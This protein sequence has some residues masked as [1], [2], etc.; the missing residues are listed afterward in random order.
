MPKTPRRPSRRVSDGTAGVPPAQTESGRNGRAPLDAISLALDKA[1]GEAHE[2]RRGPA[3]AREVTFKDFFTDHPPA[4]PYVWGRHTHAIC[5]EIQ[6]AVETIERGGTYY[7]IISV[8]PRHGKSDQ[9][10]RR[11]GP[12][13]LL[14]NPDCEV[15]LATYAAEISEGFSREARRCFT[16][17]APAYGVRLSADLNQVGAWAIDGHK[18]AF[19]AVGLGGAI[20]GRGAS[21]MIVDDYCKGRE[22]AESEIIRDRVW[23]SF[24]NDLM[25]RRAPAHAVIIVATRWHE[26]DL[27]GRILSQMEKDAD[28]PKFRLVNFPAGSD[29]DGW[30]FPERFKPE[31]YR[32]TRAVLG[33]YGW[34]SLYQGNPKP[35]GGGLLRADLVRV[36][37]E[38]AW[39]FDLGTG[40]PRVK[41][42][43]TVRWA[44]GW[45]LASTAKERIKD[46]PDYTVGTNAGFD[47]RILWV[48]D[49]VRGQWTAPKRD[50]RIEDCAR[51]DGPRVPVRIETVAGY[52]DT[53]ENMKERLRGIAKVTVKVPNTDKVTR[54]SILEPLFE[55]GCVCVL[56]A[57]WNKEWID[58][59][60]AF[61]RVKHDDQVDSL[62]NTVADDLQPRRK[63]SVSR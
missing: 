38:D 34:E 63:A 13:F 61:P 49:V 48:R 37:P 2:A 47:G 58:E 42:Q 16:E 45:D 54:A 41:G 62:V 59:L 27:V 57:P 4:R 18:G 9:A 24:R 32:S 30:L 43:A 12:W 8:P 40:L 3:R 60:N 35:R 23:D 44:R 7:A 11:A 31:W 25:T 1:A 33:T 19:Y 5:A 15:I 14:R 53:A 51:R 22:E 52:K 50:S 20:T 39:P 21:L 55:A 6:E 10:S 46:S 36:V 17:A 29:D 26:D 56:D 28:F